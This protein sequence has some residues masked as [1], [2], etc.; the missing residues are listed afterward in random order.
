MHL[1]QKVFSCV[2]DQ[3]PFVQESEAEFV[4]AL[5][6]HKEEH[7]GDLGGLQRRSELRHA[8]QIFI[9]QVRLLEQSSHLAVACYLCKM[10]SMHRLEIHQ[11]QDRLTI[12]KAKLSTEQVLSL[13]LSQLLDRVL[14]DSEVCSDKDLNCTVNHV[15]VHWVENEAHFLNVCNRRAKDAQLARGVLYVTCCVTNHI[16]VSL[17]QVH[18][19]ADLL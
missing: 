15:I 8:V 6:V 19:F 12:V 18:L 13:V 11:I 1:A 9:L 2:L 7:K 14:Q 17:Q 4:G 10:E 16:E 5:T 3:T